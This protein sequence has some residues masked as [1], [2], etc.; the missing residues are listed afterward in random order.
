MKKQVLVS[1]ILAGSLVSSF[2]HAEEKKETSQ[3]TN[4]SS[5]KV[6]DV[7]KKD[8]QVKDIDDEITNAR[9]R[10]QLGSK[11]RWSFKSDFGF[12][13]GSVEKPFDAIRP[14]YRAGASVESLA[15]INGNV[16]VNYRVTEKDNLSFGTGITI[17]DPL[18]GN[19]A[20]PVIDPRKQSEGETVSRY[21]ISTPYLDWSRGY[22]AMG[23]QQVSGATYSHF[24]DSDS[25]D[26]KSFGNLSLSQ[27]FLADF[28]NSNFSGG[29]NVS[30]DYTFY[31]GDAK[32]E[33]TPYLQSGAIMRD[34]YGVGLFPF[35]EYSIS[36]K[37]SLRTVF[38]YFQF[39]HYKN[40]YNNPQDLK[41]RE[42][43]QS[44]GVGISITRDIYLYPNVQFTPKDIRAD[45]TNVALSTNINL[46]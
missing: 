39:V 7:Q 37:Y 43:Y 14:N 19:L 13:G 16:G 34:D 33:Y 10:A 8:E 11:S 22:K 40:E 46:F 31:N 12:N 3:T 45:R 29:V 30:L 41:Q 18:H 4:S 27:T 26:L 9:L 23:M 1:L 25:A 17:M 24:T 5:V 35:A 21:Q 36:D 6:T 28:G 2:A 44:V 38:G 42:P 32:A 20:K 15:V